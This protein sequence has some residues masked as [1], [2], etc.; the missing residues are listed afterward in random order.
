MMIDPEQPVIVL[1]ALDRCDACPAQAYTV[2]V[3]GNAQEL[4][5]CQHHLHK[6]E[7]ALLTEGW[8]LIHDMSLLEEFA[9]SENIVA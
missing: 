6:H 4:L 5:F 1:T 8:T 9:S 7:D 3:N 2:A